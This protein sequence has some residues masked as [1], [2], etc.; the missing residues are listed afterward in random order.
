MDKRFDSTGSASWMRDF[1]SVGQSAEGAQHSD[2]RGPPRATED[3]ASVRAFASVVHPVGAFFDASPRS[4]LRF[5]SRSRRFPLPFRLVLH[6]QRA[7][8]TKQRS[9]RRATLRAAHRPS[10]RLFADHRRLRA[11]ETRACDVFVPSE[12]PN[13]RRRRA[14]PRPLPRTRRTKSNI[15]VGLPRPARPRLL[16]PRVFRPAPPPASCPSTLTLPRLLPAGICYVQET[17][18]L[19]RSRFND[20]GPLPGFAPPG[21]AD[22]TPTDAGLSGRMPSIPARRAASWRRTT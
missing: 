11:R 21:D 6:E 18:R 17:D 2:S 12:T 4:R 22:V 1:L 7:R 20:L 19:R 8:A 3:C 10:P 15:S 16:F 9:T 13:P 5:S 14:N